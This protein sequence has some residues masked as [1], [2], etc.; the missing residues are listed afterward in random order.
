LIK[1]ASDI[2][3][4]IESKGPPNA[5][6]AKLVIDDRKGRRFSGLTIIFANLML[7]G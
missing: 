3:A 2:Q 4:G 7:I 5:N 6:E 1:L